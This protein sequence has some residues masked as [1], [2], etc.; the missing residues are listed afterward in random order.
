M[1]IGKFQ[2]RYRAVETDPIG[3]SPI[4]QPIPKTQHQYCQH[5]EA[6]KPLADNNSKPLCEPAQMLEFVLVHIPPFGDSFIPHLRALPM[7]IQAFDFR[8]F[9][10]RL[11]RL[12]ERRAACIPPRS[13]GAGT[14]PPSARQTTRPRRRS[15]ARGSARRRNRPAPS[16]TSCPGKSRP[17][18]RCRRSPC[19]RRA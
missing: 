8:K 12:L 17:P 14:G 7:R 6:E 19:A 13:C 16:A 1:V 9:L 10:H 11:Q 18:S 15:A 2:T 4:I 5:H 3:S